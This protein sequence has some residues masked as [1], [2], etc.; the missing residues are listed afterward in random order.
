M[1]HRNDY[2]ELAKAIKNYN[3]YNGPKWT[4]IFLP[5]QCKTLAIFCKS[6]NPRFKEQVW[7]DYIAGKCGPHGGKVK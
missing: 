3:N 7:L 2:I 5:D 4:Q 6:N 1:L